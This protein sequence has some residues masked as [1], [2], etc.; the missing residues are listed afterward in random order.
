MPTHKI[1]QVDV[2]KPELA[3]KERPDG[4]I[5]VWRE[6]PLGAYPGHLS[7]R[8]AHWAA[9]TPD[10]TWMAER[11]PDGD[12][13]KVSYAELMQQIESIAQALLDLELSSDKPVMILSGN[14]LK[15]AI[16]ALA[17]QHVGIPS[18]AISSASAYA[19]A[20]PAKVAG[21]LEQITPGAVF[22][23]DAAPFAFAI[24]QPGFEGVTVICAN[25]QV[26]NR[27]NVTWEQLVSTKPRAELAAAHAR[28]RPDDVAKFL[29][30][31]GTTGS[32]KAVIQ[33]QKMM[34]AN[35]Q[36]VLDC[37]TFMATTPPVF[38][39]WAPWSHTASGNK[40][41]NMTIYNGGTYY[42]DTGKP[43]PNGM[44]ETIRN[45]RE[46][47]P[48]WYFNV[49]VGY[50][51]L[52]EAM[53]DDQTLRETFFKDLKML[54]YAGAGLSAQLWARLRSVSVETIGEEILLTTGLGATETGPFSLYCTDPQEN[55]GNIGIPAQGV[56]IKLIPTQGK[57]EARLSGPNMTPG[58]WR[59]DKKTAEAFDEEGY[60]CIGD[61][62]RFAEA[63]DA[64]KGFFFDGRI[65][66]NFKLSS[67]TWVSVGSVR[68]RLNDAMQGL[69]RDVV[70]TGEGHNELAA[71]LIPF[72]PAIERVVKGGEGMSDSEL[73]NHPSLK[74]KVAEL[75][76]KDVAAVSGSSR[77]VRRVMFM[78]Q[79]LEARLGEV[80]DKGTV[81]QKAVLRHHP[82]LIE[83]IYSENP[84]VI[85]A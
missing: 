16:L 74:A 84:H 12:W 60:Y 81:N 18:A 78:E 22:V 38:V 47:S 2:W 37:Y 50:E 83:L 26:D 63:G 21:I 58:Y 75:L 13:I 23:E 46:I 68:A 15:H 36:Q 45:L 44:A 28:V 14:S 41:F 53:D 82:D 4:S 34:C 79:P 39:D 8:I 5:L 62:L 85:N 49:P 66:E 10:Q 31:S 69:V 80:T 48:T 77:R 35:M 57:L 67:G 1:R 71:L 9:A 51:A 19:S 30:T 6:D 32:P 11:G 29:F 64:T 76:A 7:E 61:A 43:T 72:R 17:A 25:G 3:M 24:S 56:T 42:I 52:L 70:I 20:D 40:V 54:M 27:K 55:P 59:D 73:L 33:T 65:A